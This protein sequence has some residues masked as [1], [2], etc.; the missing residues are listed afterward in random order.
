MLN[1]VTH[2]TCKETGTALSQPSVQTKSIQTRVEDS[3]DNRMA[4][5][6]SYSGKTIR[7]LFGQCGN[8]CAAPDCTNPIIA[9]GTDKSD[10]AV[11]GQICHIYAASDNG[12]RGKPGMPEEERN[13]PPNLILLCGVHHPLVD[14]QYETYPASLLIN[15]K[16]KHEAKYSVNT[17]EAVRRETDLQ[18]HAFLE[19][20]SDKEI[21]Q[22]VNRLRQARFL[23]GFD[24][25]QE[26]LTLA[27]KVETSEF[28]GGSR[29]VRAKALAWCA[30]LLARNDTVGRAKELL[31]KSKELAT[32]T[33]AALADVFITAVTDKTAALRVCPESPSRIT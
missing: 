11:I 21:E 23:V 24:A 5:A 3:R 15:W 32:T 7:T 31:E 1:R 30:R 16:K 29:E 19:R 13:S 9:P 25:R 8:Q 12:P 14:K 4:I 27:S 26:A 22:A 20:L 2:W 18:K 28:S 10:A 6:R 17:A 33:D